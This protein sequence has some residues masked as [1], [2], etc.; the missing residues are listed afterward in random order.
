MSEI[1]ER[2]LI[3]DLDFEKYKAQQFCDNSEC[4]I[5]GKVGLGNIR[6]QSSKNKQ[7]YCNQCDNHWV[8]TKGTFFY[9]LKT[10]VKVVVEVLKL[11]A[12][13]MGV[14][15]VCRVKGVTA[16]SMRSWLAKAS[17]HVEEIS[18]YLQK[19]MHLTQ[20]Q[21]DE[22]WSFILKKSQTERSRTLP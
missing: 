17:D 14:N 20:C 2:N 3:V 22:F 18:A 5:F 12:E 4:S 21:I 1:R 19:E 6:T 9:H 13:G 11:L 10:P 15:A 8:I 7:V 16:D